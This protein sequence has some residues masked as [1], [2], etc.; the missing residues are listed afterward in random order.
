[1]PCTCEEPNVIFTHYC[2]IVC[3]KCGHESTSQIVSPND[4]TTYNS[5]NARPLNNRMYNRPDRWKSLVRKVVGIHSGP[6]KHDPVWK[7]L[8]ANKDQIVETQDVYK[9]LRRSGLKHK[10]Y[11]CAHIFAK[12]FAANYTQPTHKPLTVETHL[13]AYFKHIQRM[14]NSGQ[15]DFFFSYAWLLEQGLNVFGHFEYLPYVKTLICR[16]RRHKYV[17]MLMTLYKTHAKTSGRAQLDIRSQNALSP[18]AIPRNQL[19]MRP[20]PDPECEPSELDAVPSAVGSG[21]VPARKCAKPLDGWQTFASS[22][23]PLQHHH[24]Q[25][26]NHL[27]SLHNANRLLL[28]RQKARRHPCPR[29]Y[30]PRR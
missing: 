24:E 1:M 12:C 6:P 27:D 20:L 23:E 10:H 11:Q 29:Q 21:H 19:W 28:P 13:N 8:D 26:L 5:H 17:K 14:W 16:R 22:L 2:T 4:D 30:P 3:T 18:A 15:F 7:Y 25:I 9:V